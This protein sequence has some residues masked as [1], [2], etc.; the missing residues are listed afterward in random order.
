MIS[1]KAK[2]W[3][4]NGEWDAK[5]YCLPHESIYL[6][7]LWLFDIAMENGPNRNRWFTS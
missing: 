1:I 7:T 3:L 4:V 6:Y 5:K 2:K